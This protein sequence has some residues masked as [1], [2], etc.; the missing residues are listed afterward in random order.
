MVTK[1]IEEQLG[2]PP[3]DAS[4]EPLGIVNDD[5]GPLVASY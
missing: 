2:F 1:W 4:D 3:P 5:P